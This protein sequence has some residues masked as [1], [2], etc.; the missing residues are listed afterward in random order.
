MRWTVLKVAAC[1]GAAFIVY[2]IKKRCGGPLCRCVLRL[3]EKV[4]IITGGTSGLGLAVAEQLANRGAIII[5]TARD[6]DKGLAIQESLRE[7]T[8]NPK[9]FC[10][11]LDLNN[12]VSI[13]Q[14]VSR[15]NQKCSKV[16]LLIN[17]AGV[18]FH[19]P[20]ETV[21][22]FDV[23]F[24]TNYLG[25]F[26]LTELLLPVLADQSRVIF[27]SSA[28][29][30]L[31]QSL[32]L[33]SACIFDEGATGTSARF[34]SYA[35]A[36]LC[37]LLYSKTFAQRYKDR[38][39]RAYSVDPGSVETPMYRHFPFLTNPIL[40]AIQ[41]PIRFIVV[42]SPFQGAQTVLHCALS[43]KLGSE[44][45]LYYADLETKTP[46]IL[47]QDIQL[48]SQLYDYSRVWA[49]LSDFEKSKSA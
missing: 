22:K 2:Y 8:K 17:N 5:F 20:K 25:H 13:H 26:L 37:L 43:P 38:G 33:K 40:K 21:D 23:T 14:F 45:G 31:T 32:D 12:F 28:A 7:R 44:T 1:V 34:Q 49:G 19:P 30:S 29:H 16:D 9:I 6:L 18:F 4:V 36:K 11:Y 47:S 48:S 3:D 24:Q 46:S 10:E 41:K 35:K 42:R 27:L 15:V 39:I